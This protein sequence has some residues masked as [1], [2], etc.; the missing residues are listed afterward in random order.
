MGDGTGEATESECRLFLS[1]FEYGFEV[2]DAM[3]DGGLKSSLF[4]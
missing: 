2:S 1:L 4:G 3:F